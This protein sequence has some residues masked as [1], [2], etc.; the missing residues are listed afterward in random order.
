MRPRRATIAT[1]LAEGRLERIRA[2]PAAA[3]DLLDHAA[4]HVASARAIAPTD[5][6]G[7]Y[8]LAYD[9]ARKAVAA[10]MLVAGYRAKADRPG[11][12]APAVAYAEEALA[13][14]ADAAAL[15]ALDQMRRT[16]NRAEYSGLA[17]GTAQIDA[18]VAVA[19]EIVRAVRERHARHG[20]GT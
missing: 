13:A 7:A 4:A 18:D 5:P 16:R 19:E 6:V 12:H 20:T 9:A 3:H 14:V 15:G 2:D 10:D 8:Q 11:A 1:L 17:V